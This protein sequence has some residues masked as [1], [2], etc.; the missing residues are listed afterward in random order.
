MPNDNLCKKIIA[1]KNKILIVGGYGAVGSI[2]ADNLSKKF[3]SQII[4]AG[5]NLS[6]A[7]KTAEKLHHKVIPYQLNINNITDFSILNDVHL[8]IMCLD[9]TNTDF[10]EYCISK[11]IHYIDISAQYKTLKSI[12]NLKSLA[13]ENKSTVVLSVGL[14]PGIT[15]LLAKYA[16]TELQNTTSIDIFVLLGLG[17]KHGEAA[18]KW[19]FNNIDSQYQLS[20]NGKN[21]IMKSFTKP[22]QTELLGK[23]SFYLFD[24]SDQHVLLNTLQIPKV[25]TRMAF[26]VKWFTNLTS[27]LR[28]LKI[29]KL[30]K[31]EKIQNLA[32]KSFH[33]FTLGTDLYAV[34]IIAKNK[35]GNTKE[36]SINGNN[37]GKITAIVATEIAMIVLNNDL[38]HGVFHSHQIVKDIPLFL[39][40]L[41]QY[42]SG[43]QLKI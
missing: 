7:K 1:M 28:K 29:T 12:E 33:N 39:N 13:I 4:V 19:T 41:K 17:E 18:Y 26:D 11:N 32:I 27:I 21:K 23:R 25:E 5:R 6:K 35:S 38:P 30:F 9:Q 3:P 31:N 34:K 14:A 8:V 43:F 37:E 15:N 20:E 24:F 36:L 42:D 16:T 10:V 22:I 40:N 2:I